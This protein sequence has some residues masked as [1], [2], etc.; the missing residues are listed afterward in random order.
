MTI[1][2]DKL[3]RLIKKNIRESMNEADGMPRSPRGPVDPPQRHG[4]GE[5]LQY[6]PGSKAEAWFGSPSARSANELWN[7]EIKKFLRNLQQIR[8]ST[9]D[10][11]DALDK[12]QWWE[13]LKPRLQQ[14]DRQDPEQLHGLVY[15]FLEE[16]GYGNIEVALQRRNLKDFV[17]LFTSN[18]GNIARRR[19]KEKARD[20]DDQ[21]DYDDRHSGTNRDSSDTT[22]DTA[23]APAPSKSSK[24]DGWN[25]YLA[26]IR[27]KQSPE[28]VRLAAGI[29]DTWNE[30][31]DGRFSSWVRW[32]N[33]NGGNLSVPKAYGLMQQQLKAKRGST[34]S[35][36]R[37]AVDAP[38]YMGADRR[39]KPPGPTPAAPYSGKYSKKPVNESTTQLIQ[40]LIKEELDKLDL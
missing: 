6:V 20:Y 36:R 5:V 8:L 3:M 31:G 35:P 11:Q 16:I 39:G 40:R 29:R 14:W 38:D 22:G 17:S 23:A 21:A 27:R 10:Q 32:Y 19:E 13:L 15:E 25:T 26:A 9:Q 24:V 4:A 34:G 33:D 2:Q 37:R 28:N 1:N 30:I 7:A 18:A 12:S